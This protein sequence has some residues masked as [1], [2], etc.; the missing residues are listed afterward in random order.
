MCILI[1]CASVHERV[2]SFLSRDVST[3]ALVGLRAVISPM[4]VDTS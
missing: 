1:V 4:V 3:A 2:L